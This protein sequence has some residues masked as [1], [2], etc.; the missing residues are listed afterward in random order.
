MEGENGSSSAKKDLAD[1]NF[2]S[3][4]QKFPAFQSLADAI[5]SPKFSESVRSLI[6]LLLNFSLCF[7][8][9]KARG[10]RNPNGKLGIKIK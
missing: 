9:Q 2:V 8:K 7:C 1:S 10:K 6:F 3:P 4:N 5:P